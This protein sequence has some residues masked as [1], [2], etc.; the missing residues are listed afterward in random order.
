M[1]SRERSRR[2]EALVLAFSWSRFFCFFIFLVFLVRF[3]LSSSSSYSP[4]ILLAQGIDGINHQELVGLWRNPAMEAI[5]EE[6]SAA[7]LT[8]T[9]TILQT[10]VFPD[11]ISIFLKYPPAVQLLTKG[12]L[13]C[14]YLLNT[15]GPQS[16][17]TRPPPLILPALHVDGDSPENQIVRCPLQPR[18]SIATFGLKSGSGSGPHLLSPGLVYRWDWLAYE[19]MIDYDNSTVVFIK[20]FNLRSDRL[21]DPNRFSCVYGSDLSGPTNKLLTS[22]VISIGQEIVRC[23]TPLAVLNGPEYSNSPFKVSV[24]LKGRV[25]LPS[26]ARLTSRPDLNPPNPARE[27]PLHEMCVCT[28]LRNQARFL[29]E[30]IM[31]H[32]HVGVERWFLYD[33]NSEDNVEE[34]LDWLNNRNYNVSRHVWPWIKSQESG[35]AQCALRARG[36]CKWVGFIDIDEFIHF[37]SNST[38]L[39]VLQNY[40]GQN[41]VG[42]IR[43]SC[44][45]FGPSGLTQAPSKGVTVGYNCR[46]IGPERHKS[47]VRP[48]ALSPT[49]MNV[50]HHFR[51][52]DGYKHVTQDRPVMVINHY[53]YQVWQVFKE[54]FYRRVATYVA[55]WQDEQNVQSRDRAPGLGTQPI[56]PSDWPTR[57][58][59]VT[60]TRLRDR[61]LRIFDDG[62]TKMLPWE[63][64]DV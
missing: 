43:T 5:S 22:E 18:G 12:D 14:V 16:A 55:D 24:R 7:S 51:L 42:E 34:V 32:S 37:P 40:T 64:S 25:T 50:V 52:K 35:F 31:Y 38:V 21:S 47:I 58:C 1:T 28:M 45:N 3:L 53:K 54:K 8:S 44:Y 19:A 41:D 56:E 26:V 36:R 33:N 13:A 23:K 6:S 46:V 39:D 49:L 57:F 20:G 27:D 15:S 48:E 59:E 62:E 9:I 10:V 61:V 11:Q 2:R 29:K 30:W 60:D 17:Q 63:T 4:A